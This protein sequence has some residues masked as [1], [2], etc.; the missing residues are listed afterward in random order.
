MQKGL[1]GANHGG[2]A[3]YAHAHAYAVNVENQLSWFSV[4][5]FLCDITHFLTAGGNVSSLVPKYR[6]LSPMSTTV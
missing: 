3:A 4:H 1:H 2:A 5:Y 6:V